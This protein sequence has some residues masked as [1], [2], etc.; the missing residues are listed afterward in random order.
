M[1]FSSGERLTACVKRFPDVVPALNN[2]VTH[3]TGKK[4]AFAIKEKGVAAKPSTPYSRVVGVNEKMIALSLRAGSPL[5]HTREWRGAKQS[6]GKES[7]EEVL[8]GY[9]ARSLGSN[10]SLLAGWIALCPKCYY[11][12]EQ[13]SQKKKKEEEV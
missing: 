9:A 8:C 1:R 11:I 6:G 10:V 13:D 4:P 7:G 3:L 5:S 2:E 12:D